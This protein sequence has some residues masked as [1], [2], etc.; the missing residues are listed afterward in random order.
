[1]SVSCA[2]HRDTESM[3]GGRAQDAL[4]IPCLLESLNRQSTYR[5]DASTISICAVFQRF[6]AAKESD[7][8]LMS[9]VAITIAHRAR[10][11]SPFGREKRW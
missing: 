7:R 6:P 4:A 3:L 8:I 2:S 1:V 9:R 11:V 5:R 10:T